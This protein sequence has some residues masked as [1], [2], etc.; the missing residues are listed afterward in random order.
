MVQTC[1]DGCTGS[2][3]VSYG[4]IIRA[5]QWQLL[6]AVLLIPASQFGAAVIRSFG[7]DQRPIPGDSEV[8][9]FGV[10]SDNP[11]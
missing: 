6:L 9:R 5:N 4:T 1:T 10:F 3:A 2:A 11:C 8:G 7:I